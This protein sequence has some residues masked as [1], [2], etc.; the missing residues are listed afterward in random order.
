MGALQMFRN[1]ASHQPAPLWNIL[2]HLTLPIIAILYSITILPDKITSCQLPHATV[3]IPGRGQSTRAIH[4]GP[5]RDRPLLLPRA[6][7]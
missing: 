7:A 1:R 4:G 5:A 6:Q 3:S 2:K